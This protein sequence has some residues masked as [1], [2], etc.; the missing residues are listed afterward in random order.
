MTDNINENSVESRPFSWWERLLKVFISPDKAFENLAQYPKV[1]FPMLIIPIGIIALFLPLLGLYKEYMQKLMSQTYADMGMESI[2]LTDGV[3]TAQ[4]IGGIVGAV[5]M[6]V[7][8]WIL[9]SAIINGFSG[10]VNGTG[11][12]KQS[13]SVIT[14]AYLPVLLGTVITT[15]LGL[16]I[17]EFN[18]ETSLAIF[19]PESATGGFLYTILANLDIFIIWYQVLAIIGISKAYKISKGSSSIL[20]LGTWIVYILVSAGLGAASIALTNSIM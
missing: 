1:L 15:I 6:I 10:F 3:L 11:T 2:V 19:L 13:L 20:V 5:I 7:V 16:I 17:G 4:A 18:V 14:Y 9:K 8:G 12:F